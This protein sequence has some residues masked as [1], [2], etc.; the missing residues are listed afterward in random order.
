MDDIKLS[1]HPSSMRIG[2]R[3]TVYFAAIIALFVAGS[4]LSLWQF[5]IYHRHVEDLDLN[6]QQVEAVLHVN[7]N[8]LA[9][10]QTLQSV[11]A[12]RDPVELAR[13]LQPFQTILNENIDAACRA[14]GRSKDTARRQA[15][16][17][18]VLTYFQQ[19]IPNQIASAIEMANAGDWQALELR[20]IYQARDM[21]G[22]LQPLIQDIDNDAA[23]ERVRS[24]RIMAE[25]Q[26]QGLGL[27]LSFGS[28]LLL[29]AGVLAFAATQSITRPLKQLEKGAQAL[30]KGDF[31]CRVRVGGDDELALLGRAYNQAAH[32]L[33]VLYCDLEKLVAERTTELEAAKTAAESA[34]RLKS[35]FL[36]NMSHEIRTPMN[37]ILGMTDLALDTELTREQREYMSCVKSSADAL[38]TVINDILDFSKMEAGKFLIDPVE[39]EVR[40]ALDGVMRSLALRAHQKALELLCRVDA[41]VP[42][43]VTVDMD[44]VRQVL[45]NLLGNA[46]KFTESGEVELQVSAKRILEGE[47]RLQFLVRDTGI[48]IPP[49]K[50]A[51]I[52]EAFVQGD[53]SVT[54]RYGG[55]GLGLTISARLVQMMNG[56]L[57]VESAPGLGSTFRFSV[58]CQAAEPEDGQLPVLTE[59][60]GHGNA[61]LVVDDNAANREILRDILTRWGI[62]CH[63]ADNG[64]AA[65]ERIRSA[66]GKGHPYA[67]ILLDAEMPEMDGFA[68]AQHLKS[69]PWHTGALIMMLSSAD[70]NEDAVRCQQLGLRTYVVKPIC[71][72]ELH[73]AVVTTLAENKRGGEKAVSSESQIQSAIR[74]LRI[75]LAEDNPVNQTLALRLLQKQGHFAVLAKTGVEAVEKS[76]DEP[77]DAILMD[78]QMPEMDGFEAAQKIRQ[79]EKMTGL[80]VPIFALTAHAMTGDKD[81]CLAAGMDGYLTKPIRLQDLMQALESLPPVCE[82]QSMRVA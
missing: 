61:V 57:Q 3:L 43:R 9:Y 44:R 10:Q 67:L 16:T 40:P 38:L 11:V 78:L 80:H 19:I 7:N 72:K 35:E 36:A 58:P 13:S 24:L 26:K 50:Q 82:E 2:A 42:Q 46:I 55:T 31:S 39:A 12:K 20:L 5:K 23:E 15:M 41:S 4:M 69:S 81:R 1:W 45:I 68:V 65:L 77:F 54:R 34:N 56:Q 27:I 79:R 63:I 59:G 51:G 29:M 6:A 14:L 47:T 49:D 62:S 76:A 37:G 73:G 52:F 48:G 17:I 74:P 18:M 60:E 66:A 22:I 75:L 70:L 32:Q 64:M 21:S 25:A 33:Q 53:G 28:F 30:G 8:V 71:E